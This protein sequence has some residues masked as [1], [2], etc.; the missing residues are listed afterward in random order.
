MSRLILPLLLLPLSLS[1]QTPSERVRAF[2]EERTGYT[3]VGNVET[4]S[5]NADREGLF[6]VELESGSRYV[7][8]GFCDDDC[9]DLDLVLLD[10]SGTEVTSDVLADAEPVLSFTAEASGRY[11]IRIV[12]V[13]C[14]V[15]PCAYAV[16]VYAGG[17]GDLPEL[18]RDMEGRLARFRAEYESQGFTEMGEPKN[19][20]LTTGQEIRFPLALRAGLEYRIVAACDNDCEDLDLLL[21]DATGKEATSDV[22]G[23]AIPVLQVTPDAAGEYRVA[24]LMVTCTAEPC[25]YE[26]LT[27][28]RGEGVGPGGAVVTGTVVSDVTHR[29]RLEAGDQK[30][31]EGE[32]YDEYTVE[33]QAGQTIIVD[34][35]SDDFDTYLILEVQGGDSERNDDHGDEPRHSH[36]E[37]VAPATGTYSILVTSFSADETGGYVLR[38]MVTQAG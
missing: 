33:A 16:G 21:F 24:V 12:M 23:D 30:L 22:L 27:F 4:G 36:I 26:V 31:R 13:D 9:G 2:A 28:A 35:R 19:G 11:Q 17:E 14:S 3:L 25:G 15:G 8:V 20:T 7:V 5:L 1:A 18:A 38:A 37:M 32:Y 10:P 34:L 29:G 6:P